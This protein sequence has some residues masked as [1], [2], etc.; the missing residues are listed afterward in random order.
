MRDHLVNAILEE[1]DV[2][3]SWKG[4]G[5]LPTGQDGLE[6]TRIVTGIVDAANLGQSVVLRS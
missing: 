5:R 3:S 1:V 2:P 6:Q 4:G